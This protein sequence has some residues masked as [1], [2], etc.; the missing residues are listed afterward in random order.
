M[1]NEVGF[2]RISCS[3][4]LSISLTKERLQGIIRNSLSTKKEHIFKRIKIS[5]M[6]ILI[7][8]ED[9]KN[10]ISISSISKFLS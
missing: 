10:P 2:T 1:V 5:H 8:F 9:L 4:E 3:Y 7:I 6:S